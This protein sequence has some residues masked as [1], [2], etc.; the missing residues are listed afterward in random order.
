MVKIKYPEKLY[1]RVWRKYYGDRKEA[2]DKF[3]TP[4]SFDKYGEAGPEGW[5][6]DHI[7]PEAEGGSND[8]DNFQ[9]LNWK[10]NQI[11]GDAIQGKVKDISFKIK[12]SKIGSDNKKIG[13]M[14]IIK[15]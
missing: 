1:I 9:P 10:N 4:I 8:F 11:K 12:S 5:E 6:L 2:V 14:D 7:Y 3:D 15:K 13:K